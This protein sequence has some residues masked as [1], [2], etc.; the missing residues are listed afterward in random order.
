[1]R[2][3]KSINLLIVIIFAPLFSLPL[4]EFFHF[5]V[6]SALG[7]TGLYITFPTFI[8]GFCHWPTPFPHM[9]VAYLAGGLG[10]GIVLLLLALRA[11]K[12]PS[13][14]DADEAFM[15]AVF[16]GMQI[17]YGFAELSLA[18]ASTS[19]CFWWLSILGCVV[20]ALPMAIWRAPK[21][22]DFIITE[23]EI[24]T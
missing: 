24:C 2:L 20:G 4:H 21:L 16:G 7:G 19:H 1:M 17:G 18:F 9:W 23:G 10:T 6:G 15:F 11:I 8:S 5:I 3:Q 12:T 14:W 22:I 13:K